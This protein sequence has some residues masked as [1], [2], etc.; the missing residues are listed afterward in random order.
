M[1]LGVM[2]KQDGLEGNGGNLDQP[3][4]VQAVVSYFGPTDLGRRIFPRK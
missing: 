1:L 3:S 2:D 4:K